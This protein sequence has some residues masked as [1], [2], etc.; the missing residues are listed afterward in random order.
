MYLLD[1]NKI[2]TYSN[3]MST[4]MICSTNNFKKV[5]VEIEFNLSNIFKHKHPEG[6]YDY[7]V[8]WNV[9]IEENIMKDMY[10]NK[11]ILYTNE[12]NVLIL[13]IGNRNIKI[14]NLKKIINNIRK[15]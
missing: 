11:V 14:I 13:N 3:R 9:D 4:D 6:T 8:C 12:N 1:I 5:L 2:V 10:G 7:I 15:F